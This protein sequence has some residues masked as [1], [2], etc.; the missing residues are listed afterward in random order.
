MNLFSKLISL[1]LLS[2]STS[3]ASNI[4]ADQLE[5]FEN[6]IRPV[7][8]ESCYECHNSVDKKK[9]KLALDWKDPLLAGG[10][11]GLAVIPGNPKDSLLIKSIKHLDDL[12]MPSKAPKLSDAVIADFEKWIMMGAPDPRT[13]KPTK[14]DLTKNIQP[15]PGDSEPVISKPT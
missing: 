4:P 7:L 5:F 12:E 8:A 10:A 15:K 2:A 3:S 6:K 11:E 13:K 9:G 1:L 14:E